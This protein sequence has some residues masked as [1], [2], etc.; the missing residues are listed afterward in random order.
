ML[1]FSANPDVLRLD[2][3]LKIKDHSLIKYSID[4]AFGA[5][6]LEEL[7]PSGSTT[8]IVSFVDLK[9]KVIDTIPFPSGTEAFDDEANNRLSYF[10]HRGEFFTPD[11]DPGSFIVYK[12]YQVPIE[13]EI[14]NLTQ[15]NNYLALNVSR[16][17]SFQQILVNCVSK[18]SDFNLRDDFME[19]GGTYVFKQGALSRQAIIKTYVCRNVTI[20]STGFITPSDIA[21]YGPFHSLHQ[22]FTT[23][24][25]NSFQVNF[26]PLLAGNDYIL[27]LQLF[28][29]KGEWDC[30]SIP[31]ST[32]KRY[33]EFKIDKLAIY[34]NGGSNGGED[35]SEAKFE[36][37]VSDGDE[38]IKQEFN[39]P[40]L[41]ISTKV[42][43]INWHVTFGPKALIENSVWG[44]PPDLQVVTYG[45]EDDSFWFV[46]SV[47][48]AVNFNFGGEPLHLPY[49]R[50]NEVRTKQSISFRALPV[51]EGDYL[52]FGSE[53]WYTVNYV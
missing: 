3:S 35:E 13:E 33:L 5:V 28:G 40:D 7:V 42:I 8:P 23:A 45:V 31:F 19:V 24:F 44:V 16:Q 52:D 14:N 15:F 49:G 27:L 20:D 10:K 43:N 47:E 2:L 4:P 6:I 34:N 9:D 48:Q 46:S 30:I 36:I 21:F 39:Y 26:T 32:K 29:T 41:D 37:S 12:L 38:T 53:G 17:V 22:F 51:E 25:N 50:N 11:I 1:E 18:R